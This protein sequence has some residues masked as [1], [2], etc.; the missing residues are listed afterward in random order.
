MFAFDDG[1]FVVGQ[2]VEFVNEAVNF[3]FPPARVR[4]RMPALGAEIVNEQ[5]IFKVA[6]GV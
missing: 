2:V 4:L 3:A 5:R 1:D 6:R